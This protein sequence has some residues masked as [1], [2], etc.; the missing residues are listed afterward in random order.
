MQP[1]LGSTRA[2]QDFS[3][4]SVGTFRVSTLYYFIRVTQLTRSKIFRRSITLLT[5]DSM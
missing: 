3:R 1:I 5:V 2:Q 4:S